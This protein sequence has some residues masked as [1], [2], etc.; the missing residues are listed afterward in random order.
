[1]SISKASIQSYLHPDQSTF[2]IFIENEFIAVCFKRW[3]FYNQVS[4]L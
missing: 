4:F 1:M 2:S 3:H